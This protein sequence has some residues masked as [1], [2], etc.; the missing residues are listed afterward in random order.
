M[1]KVFHLPKFTNGPVLMKVS[2][3]RSIESEIHYRKLLFFAKILDIEPGDLVDRLYLTRDESFSLAHSLN[4]IGLVKNI[5]EILQKYD[6]I[7]YFHT[8]YYE[9]HF[10]S[11]LNWKNIVKDS[12]DHFQQQEWQDYIDSHP[13]LILLHQN[14]SE[15]TPS[16]FWRITSDH[17][18]LVPKL[19]LQLRLMGNFGFEKKIFGFAMNHMAMLSLEI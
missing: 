19:N 1:Q 15:L 6:L 5:F 17:P 9:E 4:S 18:D 12:T 2:G 8:W 13:Y 7:N 14:L 16:R 11:Y 10:P 3:L